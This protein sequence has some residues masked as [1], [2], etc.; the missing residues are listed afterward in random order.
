MQ[1]CLKE[2]KL[3]MQENQGNEGVG[4]RINVVK[5]VTVMRHGLPLNT[6]IF[7]HFINCWC[8]KFDHKTELFRYE[9]KIIKFFEKKI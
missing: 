3:H 6:S 7:Q 1:F 9:F 5:M 8:V 4:L 2:I